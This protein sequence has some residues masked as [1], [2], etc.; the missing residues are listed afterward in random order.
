[1]VQNRNKL[2]NLVIGNI[3]NSIIHE[4]LERAIANEEISNKYKKELTTSF[5][6]AKR[7]RE[8]INPVNS[9]FPYKDIEYIK[10]KIRNKVKAELLIR[11]SRGY[12][13]INLDLM[14]EIIESF[15]KKLKII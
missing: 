3:S 7:Y 8:K 6:I 13:N 12:K 2:I 4:I 1:M 9:I 14:E 15:L 11:I 10:I 5:D